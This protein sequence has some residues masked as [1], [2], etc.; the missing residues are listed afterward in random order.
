M[1][2]EG[3]KIAIL[4]ANGRLSRVV[5]RAFAASGW[6][7]RAVTRT[8]A[9]V[10]GSNYEN[11]AGDM[12]A[13]EDAIAA[14]KDCD[15]I[16]NGLNP[17]YT[18]WSGEVMAMAR[19]VIAA[20]EANGAVHL[21]PGNVYNYGTVI[22]PVVSENTPQFGD[23]RKAAI[24][25]DAENL[26]AEA[27]ADRGVKTLILRA[28]DFFGGEGRGSWFDSVIVRAIGRGKVTYPGPTDVIHAWAYLPDLSSAFVKLAEKAGGLSNFD[29]FHFAGHAITGRDMH[30][31]IER[32]MGSSLKAAN[33]PW[34][35]IRIGGL[36]YPMWR[37]IA[38]MAYLWER[39]HRLSTE[40]LEKLIGPLSMAPLDEAVSKALDDLDVRHPRTTINPRAL[41]TMAA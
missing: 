36:V 39:P 17:I 5:A 21:F 10:T 32:S 20:A 22:P 23:H 40:K 18:R 28:G 24:R 25:I 12:M 35:L 11:V 9:A 1:A 29:A 38:E 19:N 33:F 8:G 13:A 2:K 15:F 6:N 26:F 41:P 30:E 7:I 3:M 27:A 14:T 37:E 4:G 34:P 16:F 31:A